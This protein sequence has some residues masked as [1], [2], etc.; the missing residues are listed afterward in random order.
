MTGDS[1]LLDTNIILGLLKSDPKVVSLLSALEL[2][3][4]A[5]AYSS[6]TRMEL[7]GYPGIT[8]A[9]AETI[10]RVLDSLDHLAIDV[11]VEDETIRIRQKTRLKLP[12]AIICATALIHGLDLLT[13]DTQL[14]VAYKA[15]LAHS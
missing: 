4:G 1:F 5:C 9:E 3:S 15:L 10:T 14:D 12:D 7:L 8:T 11:A 2:R 6:I 13:F